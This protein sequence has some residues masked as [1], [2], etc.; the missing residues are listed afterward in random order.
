M[1]KKYSEEKRLWSLKVVETEER[2]Q[3]DSEHKIKALENDFKN[4]IEQREKLH[5][6]MNHRISE[7][8][9]Q[10]KDY[11]HNLKKIHDQKHHLQN[12]NAELIAKETQHLSTVSLMQKRVDESAKEESNAKLLLSQI[13]EKM[14]NERLDHDKITVNHIEEIQSY[15]KK[16]EE[17]ELV[18]KKLK[19]QIKLR[20]EDLDAA[21]EEAQLRVHTFLHR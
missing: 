16:L 12:E 9:N 11:E 19:E 6:E 3:K 15:K 1:K 21:E 5:S 14:E 18:I 17:R 10:I 4:S 7:L 13:K 20:E 2:V 8:H